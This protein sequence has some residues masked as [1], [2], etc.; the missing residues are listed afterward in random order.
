MFRRRTEGI[1]KRLD[2]L[3]EVDQ[4]TPI[5]RP[6]VL[7]FGLTGAGKS[8]VINMLKGSPVGPA[9]DDANL[10][11]LYHRILYRDGK[12]YTF[13]N[14]PDLDSN[15]AVRDLR[16][17]VDEFTADLLVYCI[18]DALVDVTRFNYDLVWRDLCKGKVPILLVVTGLKGKPD[19]DV[20]WY[21]NEEKIEEMKMSFDGHVCIPSWRNLDDKEYVESAEKLWSLVRAHF[22]PK[23]NVILFGEAGA[24]KSSVVNM[25]VGKA[26]A[27]VSSALRGCTFKNDAYEAIIGDKRYVIYDTAGLNEGEQGRVPHWEAI[28]ELYTLIRELDGV[29]LLVYCMRGRVRE[30]SKANWDLF[31]KVICGGNVPAI[32]IVT[33]LDDHRDPNDLF[34][35]DEIYLD[36]LKKNG[37]EPR[38]VGCFVWIRGKTNQYAESYAESKFKVRNLVARHCQMPWSEEKEKWFAAMYSE[39]YESGFV[40][41]TR[42]QLDYSTQMRDALDEFIRE[43]RMKQEDTEKLRATLLKA[44]K[45]YRR[46]LLL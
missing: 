25:I 17:F 44:E 6:L 35:W 19:G 43:T 30:N 32:A 14:T 10:C 36:L 42:K 37:M 18:E 41:S 11:N 13:W 2:L 28:K 24:G 8:S 29:S 3:K 16:V 31:N 38:H 21:E 15:D 33:G 20:W 12:T 45:R 9:F 7:I 26:V 46:R 27:K 40:R 22:G 34:K 39:V 4:S 5:G 1:S 23:H